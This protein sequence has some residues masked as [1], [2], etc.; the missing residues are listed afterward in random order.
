[1]SAG[2]APRSD[3][4]CATKRLDRGDAPREPEGRRLDERQR[5]DALRPQAGRDQRDDGAVGVPDEVRPGLEELC[6]LGSLLRPVDPRQR[7]IRPVATAIGDDEPEA[8]GQRRLRGPGRGA[9][10]DAAVDEHE[11]RP[12]SVHGDPPGIHAEHCTNFGGIRPFS[13]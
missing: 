10:R 9:V 8:V 5:G 7:R 12:F 11:A 3:T 2:A 6:D 4:I 13:A 1:M